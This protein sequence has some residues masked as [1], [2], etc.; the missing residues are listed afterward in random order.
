MCFI[1]LTKK[2]L[3]LQSKCAITQPCKLMIVEAVNEIKAPSCEHNSFLVIFIKFSLNIFMNS[4]YC[5]IWLV[6][7]SG[8][9]GNAAIVS[10]CEETVAAF[11]CECRAKPLLEALVSGW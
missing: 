1:Y 4:F 9:N 10:C 3:K 8:C 5:N 6:H 7:N 11:G 2:I